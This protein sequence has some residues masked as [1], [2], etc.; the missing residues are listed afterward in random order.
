MLLQWSKWFL[1]I[2]FELAQKMH[3]KDWL[4]LFVSIIRI[5]RSNYLSFR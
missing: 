1:G 2:S 3:L 5:L 4:L